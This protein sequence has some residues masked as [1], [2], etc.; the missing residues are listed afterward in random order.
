MRTTSDSRLAFGLLLVSLLSLGA[1]VFLGFR[2][3][4][5]RRLKEPAPPSTQALELAGTEFVNVSEAWGLGLAHHDVSGKGEQG[6]VGSIADAVAPGV[7][8]LDLDDDGDLDLVQLVGRGGDTGVAI[9]RNEWSEKHVTHFVDVTAACGIRW[10]GAAQ[11]VC[12]GDVDGDGDVDLYVTAAG[13]KLLL[14]NR[15]KESGTLRFDDL[16]EEAGVAGELWHW[17]ES[18]ERGVAPQ[19][20]PGCSDQDH[21]T[22]HEV[23][24][25]S[26][27]ATFGDFDAD[28]DL[29]LYVANYVAAFNER[30]NDQRV[31]EQADRPEPAQYQPQ[32]FESLPDR[33][34]RNDTAPGGPPRFRDVTR[35]AGVDDQRGR[36]LGVTFMLI[37]PDIY[38]DLYLVND[39]TANVFL[40]NSAGPSG[41]RF[42]VATSEFGLY[43]NRSGM[44]LARGDA[45]A[46][47]DL[48]LLTTN[49]RRNGSSLFLYRLE[50]EGD[51][52]G[53]DVRQVAK[54]E[55]RGA[56]A[57]I[58]RDTIP[59][60]GWG[61]VFLD[62]DD[63]GDEDL[64]IGNGATSPRE[65][66]PQCAPER[67]L[68]FKNRG[69]GV[70]DN[71]SASAGAALQASYAAR[72]V[73]AGDLDRDG[74]LDLVIA[75]NNGPLVVLENRRPPGPHHALTVV[76][77]FGKLRGDAVNA[78]VVV[79]SGHRRMIRELLSGSSYLCQEPFEAHFGLGRLPFADRVR[80]SWPWFGAPAPT[81]MGPEP[82]TRVN[83]A[84]EQN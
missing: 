18:P 40:R 42:E 15:R 17:V 20:A 35:E 1:F 36:G 58:D 27:G 26:T 32:Q 10:T 80:V 63:D 82:A 60:V 79:E 5:S 16:T 65:Q 12:A 53:R 4:S 6:G 22:G 62:Y 77:S 84:P 51:E 73:V 54:F 34:Y 44:G 57:R 74:D 59:L 72:G 76:P 2:P 46:D 69:D 64:F 29:D 49:F 55:E 24:E 25:F 39:A 48:D 13:R 70:F 21:A 31:A 19:V 67:A 66:Q 68:L 45:D 37:D 83:I 43:D 78:V 81:M 50:V 3:L 33:L 75:Q 14:V 47:G 7:G 52:A 23:P 61:C 28:G 30:W 11:G 38:P 8:L 56:A 41:R 71:V 9:W